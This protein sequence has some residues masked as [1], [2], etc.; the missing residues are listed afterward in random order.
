M[1]LSYNEILGLICAGVVRTEYGTFDDLVN[2]SSLDVTLDDTILVEEDRTDLHTNTIW[3][4]PIYLGQREA[5]PMKLVS[6]RMLPN[7]YPIMPGEFILCATQE[8][9]YLPLDISAEYKL[10]SSMARCGLESLNAGWAD[11]GWE[12]SAFTLELTNCT[13]YTPIVIRPGDRIGQVCFFRHT[14]VP[15]EVS[16]RKRGRYNNDKTVAGVKP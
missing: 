10:K 5:L 9:F 16:Y 6:L 8:R 14:P 12:G 15:E 1:L 2:G 3:N 7:G 11:P 13:R 4:A